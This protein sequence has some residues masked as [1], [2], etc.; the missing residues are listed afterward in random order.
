MGAPS[1]LFIPF[2][3]LLDFQSIEGMNVFSHGYP[4]IAQSPPKLVMKNFCKASWS[5]HFTLSRQKC[6]RVP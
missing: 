1:L 5:P 4:R 2:R 3:H 6:L